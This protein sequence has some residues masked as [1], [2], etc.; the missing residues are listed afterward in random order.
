MC[1]SIWISTER[2]HLC[3]NQKLC[4]K[5]HRGRQ[6]NQKQTCTWGSQWMHMF[7]FCRGVCKN[8]LMYIRRA[9]STY[10]SSVHTISRAITF[11]NFERGGDNMC[12]IFLLWWERA[13]K[14]CF[15][16]AGQFWYFRLFS[17]HFSVKRLNENVKKYILSCWLYHLFKLVHI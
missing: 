14:T 2:K 3:L 1:V 7:V 9:I 11:P 15:L 10:V 12:I 8:K 6:M 5:L 13:A 4:R 16:S 17:S